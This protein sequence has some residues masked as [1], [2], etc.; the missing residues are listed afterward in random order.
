[1]ISRRH[2]SQRNRFLFL[3]AALAFAGGGAIGWITAADAQDRALPPIADDVL[4][5]VYTCSVALE[6]APAVMLPDPQESGLSFKPAKDGQPARIGIPVE[7]G[8]D[9]KKGTLWQTRDQF[10]LELAGVSGLQN[11]PLAGETLV[12]MESS[13][14]LAMEQVAD[15]LASV[16]FLYEDE[17]PHDPS[18]L[19]WERSVRQGCATEAAQPRQFDRIDN[20]LK[21]F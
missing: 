17:H 9:H 11:A 13:F 4:I 5:S 2:R 15:Y 6:S 12:A 14:E 20:L 16:I 18:L 7:L 3:L 8:D 10:S 1:M 21:S 19:T